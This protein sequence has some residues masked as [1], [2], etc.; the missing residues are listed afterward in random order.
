V[1]VPDKLRKA[2]ARAA[3]TRYAP[4]PDGSTLTYGLIAVSL[5]ALALALYGGFYQVDMLAQP[6]PL[7]LAGLG[8]FCIGVAFRLRL[9][10]RHTAAYEA[11]YALRERAGEA[12]VGD[13]PEA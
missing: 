4:K 8:A 2:N 6:V 11:E 9:Q 1:P 10:R 7:L 5:L 3:A 12:G 13:S